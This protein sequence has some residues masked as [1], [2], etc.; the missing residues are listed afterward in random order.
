VTPEGVQFRP[1][2]LAVTSSDGS[3]ATTYKRTITNTVCDNSMCLEL[4]EGGTQMKF[5]H[6][7]NST[8]R[9]ADARA[10]LDIIYS[11]ADE[12]SAQV[13]R[14]VDQKVTEEQWRSILDRLVPNAEDG[15]SKRGVSMANTKREQLQ[16]LWASDPR[17]TEFRGTAWAVRQSFSTWEQHIKATKADTI[18]VERNQTESIDGTLERQEALVLSAIQGMD[19]GKDLVL[20]P[21]S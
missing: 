16:Q 4:S 6:S 17:V 20:A 9:I 19:F 2:L 7:R 15:Q 3:L 1:N 18:R 14:L 5:K 12:F 10:A 21:L 13:A 8:T 11:A